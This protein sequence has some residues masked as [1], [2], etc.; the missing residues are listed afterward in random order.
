[1]LPLADPAVEALTGLQADSLRRG[2]AV[3]PE[4]CVFRPVTPDE[5]RR[6]I[7][8]AGIT[9]KTAE[10]RAQPRSLRRSFASSLTAAGVDPMMVA[11]L[12]RHALPGGAGLTFG[13]YCAEGALL[14]RKRAALGQTVRWW[15]NQGRKA[16]ATAG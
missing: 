8:A 6:D 13:T 9:P 5:W 10:G 16:R 14:E 2:Q 3:G 4:D 11:I 7:E 15:R 1:M 12:M